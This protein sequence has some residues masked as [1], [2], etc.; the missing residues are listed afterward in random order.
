M[1]PIV[2]T[3]DPK[4][5]AAIVRRTLHQ[6]DPQS[7]TAIIDRLFGD[8]ETMF[9]G[10][11]LD[12][13]PLDTRYHDFEHTLQAALCLSLLIESRSRAGVTPRL[14][15]RLFEIAIAGVLLHDVGYLKLRSDREGTGAKYTYVHVTRSCAFAASYLPAIGFTNAEV[16]TVE[17]AIRCTGP[18]SRIALIEFT[19]EIEQ[20]LGCALA[21]AD[22]L[23]Q[24]AA[25]DYIEELGFLFDEFNESDN[26]YH[27][28]MEKRMFHSLP[29]LIAKS[30]NFW[31]CFVL[32][33][34]NDDYRAVYRYLAD[35]YPGGPNAYIE[36][37][38][39]NI[40]RTRS[41]AQPA[42]DSILAPPFQE[43]PR[44]FS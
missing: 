22:F 44:T 36:A 35:P 41:M 13:H 39:R 19:D 18:R 32:P 23:G 5:V 28:P 37:V 29:D 7:G 25:P 24:M 3:K 43:C 2:D 10:R 26:F 17:K 40:A 4:A 21:S 9:S 12:Y 6:L 14:S 16:D 8:I 33:R 20:F 1:F 27:V 31:E 38:E 42:A 11:Y 30:A 34:L 15:A